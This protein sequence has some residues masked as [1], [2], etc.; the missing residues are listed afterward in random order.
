MKIHAKLS[1]AM[2]PPNALKL[3]ASL[4]R[5]KS[6]TCKWYTLLTLVPPEMSCRGPLLSVRSYAKVYLVQVLLFDDTAPTWDAMPGPLVVGEEVC[7]VQVLL[8]VDTA[9]T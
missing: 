8:T 2:F 7:H 5:V 6:A 3:L 9:P 1:P 4:L